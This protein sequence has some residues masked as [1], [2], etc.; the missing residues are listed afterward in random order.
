MNEPKVEINGVEYIPAKKTI[1]NLN[2]FVESLMSLFW[3]AGVQFSEDKIDG[4][5]ISVNDWGAGIEFRE[6][7]NILAKTSKEVK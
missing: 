4:L 6:F 3:G 2:I 5:Y 7:I 1:V